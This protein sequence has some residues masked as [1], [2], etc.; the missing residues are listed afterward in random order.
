MKYLKRY[1]IFEAVIHP[2]KL[3]N[4]FQV[5]SFRDLVEYGNQNNFDVVEY[6]EFY[7]SLDD[8]DKKTAP[9]K[10]VPFFALFHPQRKKPMFVL[11]N[12]NTVKMFPNFKE[13]VDDI[14]SILKNF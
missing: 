7:D 6:Q 9:P 10:G 11:N 5:H 3:E 2:P 13:I 4:D 14:K 1:K 8:I 12:E